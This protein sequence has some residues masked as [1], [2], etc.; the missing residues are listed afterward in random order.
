M[1]RREYPN[2]F[3]NGRWQEP[4]SQERLDVISPR[5]GEKIGYVPSASTSDV[6]RAVEA[7]RKAFYETD[8][9]RRPV[10]E[11]AE[12]CERLAT[13]I[14][15]HREEFRDLV[16][17]ELG[18]TKFLTDV[19]HSVAPTL[20]WNYYAKLG[21]NFKFAEV[22]EADLSPLAGNAGGMIMK[23]ET[24]SLVLREPVGV[25][26]VLCAFNFPLPGIAQKTAPALV[27]G[28][29]AV[30]KVPDPDPLAIFAMAD[31]IAEAGFPPGV[32]NIIATDA[33]GS[34]YLVSHPDV[35]MVTF[36]G[37]TDVGKKIAATCAQQVKPVVLELGG[38]SAAIILEDADLDS[39]IPVVA[40]VSAGTSQ[41]ESCV[42]MSRILAPRSKY[43][44][45]ASRL[46]DAFAA[47]K[48]GDPYEED[49]IVGPLISEA[50]RERVLG[51][52]QKA[53]DEGATVA[54]GG[55]VPEHLD[56][57][58]YVEPTLLTNVSNDMTV[59]QEE[60]FGPVIALIPY[61]DEEDAVRI[62]N[63]S[64]FG[65][66]GSVFTS[67]PLRGFEL[68]RRIRAGTFS[69]NTYAA[70]FNSPFGGYKESGIGREHGPTAI[71]EYLLYKTISVDPSAELP[72]E[73]VRSVERTPA[74]V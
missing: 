10:E 19:Y 33:E 16:V 20:H 26:A 3:I 40:G 34:A 24:K 30:V 41:G 52:V 64:R 37:S 5:S 59:A 21:R 74:P 12:M 31:L 8:W 49:T 28:C 1:L 70:D 18:H 71:E 13:L 11:R 39:V 69:V 73:V 43:D 36:T 47:M 17:E 53:V 42:C 61:D 60:V 35:D 63:D 68:A 45:I 51:Y 57:G 50:H 58:W 48:V 32:V 56:K 25:V 67:D 72:E 4:D 46:T 65:L 55:K 38:K 27:A 9:P 2:L 7:A 22:R 54:T 14:A 44:E 23:Y 29:T 66:A 62:A 15:E 6:D